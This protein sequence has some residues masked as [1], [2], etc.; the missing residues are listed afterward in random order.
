[1]SH[2]YDVPLMCPR[3]RGPLTVRFQLPEKI[4]LRVQPTMKTISCP[5]GCGGEINPVI[6]AEILDV[7]AGHGPKTTGQK[8]A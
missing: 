4:T 2:P 5:Y 6:H 3:C 1:M 7:W 8:L